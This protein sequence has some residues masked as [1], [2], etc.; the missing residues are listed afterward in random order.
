MGLAVPVQRDLRF[1]LFV[2]GLR[3]EEHRGRPGSA[4]VG[5]VV[6]V[7]VVPCRVVSLPGHVGL[8]VRVDRYNGSVLFVDG[9][10]GEGDGRGPSRTQVRG[11]PDVFVVPVEDDVGVVLRVQGQAGNP[12]TVVAVVG[13]EERGVG[14]G[15]AGVAGVDDAAVPAVRAVVTVE[16]HV[17]D[18][19]R[20]DRDNGVVGTIIVG[21]YAHRG[22]PGAARVGGV[23]DVLVDSC[24]VLP[25]PDHVH[26]A[27]RV[28]GQAGVSLVV[29]G[30]RGEVHRVRPIP[31][32][33]VVV[34]DPRPIPSLPHHMGDAVR[35]HLDE[36]VFVRRGIRRDVVGVG[37]VWRRLGGRQADEQQKG[38]QHRHRRQ[39]HPFPRRRLPASA[40][41]TFSFSHPLTP[42]FFPAPR[43]L[44]LHAIYDY[45]VFSICASRCRYSTPLRASR[46]AQTPASSFPHD[47]FPSVA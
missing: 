27:V 24:R 17:G 44:H 43:P 16:G 9:L 28:Q 19:V 38:R 7:L 14:P 8:A 41:R 25:L 12:P 37:P 46:N 6:D 33:A 29:D 5:R 36:G 20:A 40:G 32:G 30:L 45:L 47:C 4:R 23:P 35:I 15:A 31:G 1:L 10:G 13:A 3:G 18:A 21:G 2:D 26:V 11:V 42:F 34:P 22:G 39:G